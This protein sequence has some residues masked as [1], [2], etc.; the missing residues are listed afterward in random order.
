MGAIVITGDYTQGAGGTLEVDLGGK[1]A[2]QFDEL[3]VGGDAILDGTLTTAV[4]GTFVPAPGSQFPIVSGLTVTGVF[5]PE[6]LS[7]GLT[8]LYSAGA[9]TL[10]VPLPPALLVSIGDAA[11]VEGQSGTKLA[12]FTL[13]LDQASSSAVTVDFSTG[14]FSAD[15]RGASAGSDYVQVVGSQVTFAPGAL[16]ATLAITINGDTQG[17]ARERFK[18]LLTGASGAGI[19]DDEGI[20]TILDDDHHLIA[21]GSGSLVR[22]FDAT[23][24]AMTGSFSPFGAR[25]TG[26]VRVAMGDVNGDGV[27]DII[28][29]SGPGS[30]KGARVRVFDGADP[31][32]APLPGVLGDFTPFG[33]GYRGGVYVA[34]GDVDGDGLAEVIVSPGAGNSGQVRVYSGAD[35]TLLSKFTALARVGGGVRVAVGDVNGDGFAD[36][37]A[38]A[39]TGSAVRVFDAL[40]GTAL[41]GFTFQSFPKT[42]KTGVFVAAGDVNGDGLDDIIASGATASNLVRIFQTGG[43]QAAPVQFAIGTLKGVRVSTADVNGDGIADIVTGR[44]AGAGDSVSVFHGGTLAELFQLSGYEMKTRLGVFVG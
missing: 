41:P 12:V 13:T 29:G 24:G 38:G 17:E 44:G 14:D 7:P 9:V 21:T 36:I 20:G 23:T 11:I 16:T 2:T 10:L 32:H 34:S 39:G 33:K 25:L 26:G 27:N 31:L 30:A 5:D 4:I 43:S 40:S 18:V 37:I 22:V 1:G 35:G 28:V 19:A 3:S 15:A 6:N 8:S 42:H